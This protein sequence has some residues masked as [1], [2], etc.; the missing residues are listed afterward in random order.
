MSS[1]AR[2]EANR[3]QRIAAD[4]AVSAFVAASAGSGKT[5]LL[6]DRLLRL[7]LGTAESAGANPARIQCLTFTKAAAAEMA[8]RLQRR[9]GGWVTL[10]DERLDGALR[11]L[12]VTPGPAMRARARALFATVLDLPGGMRIGTIHAFCQSLLR[13]FPLEAEL[14]PHFRLMDDPDAAVA[15]S[16]AREAMLSGAFAEERRAA[17]RQLAGLVTTL[18]GLGKLLEKLRA[19]PDRLKAALAGGGEALEARLRHLLGARDPD[20]VAQA[21]ANE[22]DARALSAAACTLCA[23]GGTM[24]PKLGEGVAGWLGLDAATRAESGAEWR[25]LL[26]KEDGQPRSREGLVRGKFLVDNP[27]VLEALE[28][29]QVRIVALDDAARAWQVA[30]LSAALAGL[31][32]PVA[33]AYAARKRQTG[34]LD[35]GDL[36]RASSR[37]LVDPGAAWVLYK[38]D[39]GIDHLLLDEVQDTAPEQWEIAGRLSGEFFAG[40]GAAREEASQALPRTVFAVGDRKQ[41][42]Y[43]FQGA[44][45]RA[46]ETWRDILRR[47][48]TSAGEQW[49]DVPLE[50]SFRSTTP[51]LRLVDAV[52][53]QPPAADGVAAP[54]T[55]RH[56]ADRA[57]HAGSVELWPLVPEPERAEVVPWS[58][59]ERNQGSRS[60]M[61]LLADGLAGWIAGQTG[62]G[63]MLESK[64]RPLVPGDV[65]V[66]V[67]RRNAFARALVRAL[68]ARGVPVA[69]LDRLVLTEQPAVADLLALCDTLLLPEDDL[70]LACVLTSPLGGLTDDSLMALAAG[71]RGSLWS[72]L[73]DR[74]QERAEWAAAREMIATLLSRVD[75]ATPHALLG[76][77]LGR[78]GGRARLFAR[79]GPEAA[80]PVD[81]LLNAALSYARNH[82]PSLQGFVHWLRQSGAEVKREAEGASHGGQGAVRLMTVH[83]AKGLQAPLVIL[84]DTTGLPPDDGT[85][86]WADDLP[87]WSPRR[88]L[89]CRAAEALRLDRRAR[90][91]EEQNRLLYVALTRAEDRL[92]VCGLA[93]RRALSDSCW[94][95][96]VEQGFARLGVPAVPFDGMGW[97]GEAM[98]LDSAQGVAPDVAAPRDAAVVPP[99]LPG[100][101]GQAPA[102]RPLAVP[103]EPALPTPLAPSRPEGVELGPVPASD[104]PLAARDPAGARF[105]RGQL[106]HALLQHLPDLPAAGR[107]AAAL[108]FLAR[109]G[110]GLDGA[111]AAALAR[112]VLA[113]LDRP[114]LAPLFGPGGRAEVPLTGVVSGRVVGGLVDRLVVLPD[115]VLVADYKTNRVA[116]ATAEDAPAA[117]LRQMAAYRAV[118]RAIH[119]GRSVAC[120]LVWTAGPRVMPLPDS[121]LDRHAPAPAMG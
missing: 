41:S 4:P 83:G 44:D 60:A 61:Q 120:V 88:E 79:L 84:P 38:L 6:T 103:A 47:R 55:L 75:Y 29:E 65:L 121:L 22:C 7:M 19:E 23:A 66:L 5:K 16:E 98:R 50:V 35:Y 17:L 71:R 62:G 46:F 59:P 53:A 10:D 13:R 56:V 89:R 109:P 63:V 9:L 119:P 116:P 99:A 39:G 82:P 52:F 100:W 51:V 34:M 15:L 92:V 58:V 43:S 2:E 54:G 33:E 3:S 70:A 8:V 102:W 40:E 11:A 68:K 81:E 104:S 110:T 91:M 78:L 72:A 27:G 114:D 67:R 101:A 115:L 64:G 57:G 80:E 14:S 97:T 32:G 18:D 94:Y 48:V 93:R 76:E 31:A 69:G 106:A 36:I 25:K 113:I 37:L 26:L 85:V 12:E 90:E 1:S 77:A 42:I 111:A 21:L 28:A 95:R 112:E 105:R 118:L 96:L 87:V 74:A 45:P 86:C 107:E 108:R 24:A 49:R 117:Y 73:R 20:E 30:A